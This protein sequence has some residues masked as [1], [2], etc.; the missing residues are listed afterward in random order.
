MIAVV[1]A[2]VTLVRIK[3]APSGVAGGMNGFTNTPSSNIF[4]AAAQVSYVPPA[5][6]GMIGVKRRMAA[7]STGSPRDAN[8]VRVYSDI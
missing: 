7:S 3:A 5:C 6:I 4:L 2:A 8:A 1:C